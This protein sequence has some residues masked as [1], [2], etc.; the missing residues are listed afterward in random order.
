MHHCQWLELVKDCDCMISYH[1]RKANVV[2]DGLRRKTTRTLS[3]LQGIS[4]PLGIKIQKFGLE[5][6]S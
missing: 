5:L 4:I 6:V 1:L 3:M 2:A